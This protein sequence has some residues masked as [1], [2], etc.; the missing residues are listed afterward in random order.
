M[1]ISG[2][3]TAEMESLRTVYYP[4]IARVAVAFPRDKVAHALDGFGVL[5]PKREQMN[6]LGILFSSSLFP[7][8]A[9]EGYA[10]LT[11]YL[12][13]SRGPD[14]VNMTDAELLELTVADMK[15]LLGVAGRPVFEDVVR[16]PLSIPQYNVGYGTVK[17]SIGEIEARAK[18]LFLAGSYRGGIS[19]ADCIAGGK[20]A[21]E[22]VREYAGKT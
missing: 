20:A 22:K 17:E 12:G 7:Q 13:G 8:R 11:A 5:I 2:V 1:K 10:L 14:V 21:S 16:V 6:T 15:K 3:A 18:G 19:V 9:P 4:P